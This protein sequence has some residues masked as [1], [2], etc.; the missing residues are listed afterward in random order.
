MRTSD[1]H[2]NHHHQQPLQRN[3]HSTLNSNSNNVPATLLRARS[4]AGSFS[5]HR[6][7]VCREARFDYNYGSSGHWQ[8]HC[9]QDQDLSRYTAPPPSSTLSTE[10]TTDGHQI[11]I[12]AEGDLIGS[13]GS[14][15]AIPTDYEQA[16]G[17]ERLE[18]LGKMEGIDI[19]DTGP[20]D[21]S[22]RGTME[23][24][25]VVQSFGEER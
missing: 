2:R 6:L 23:S 12:K 11:E 15:G 9:G 22:R 8:G 3:L 7:T 16:T 19:F 21:A 20:L 10:T 25:I 13:G 5:P 1:A 24:P 14:P 4:E 18:I 17:L